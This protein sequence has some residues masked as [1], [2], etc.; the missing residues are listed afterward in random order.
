MPGPAWRWTLNPCLPA[1]ACL[2][3]GGPPLDRLSPDKLSLPA[4]PFNAM[5]NSAKYSKMPPVACHDCPPAVMVAAAGCLGLTMLG[6]TVAFNA[7]ASIGEH[8]GGGKHALW[9]PS[10][11]LPLERLYLSRPVSLPWA[12]TAAGPPP[13]L[14]AVPPRHLQASPPGTSQASWRPY[15]H[16]ALAGIIGLQLSYILPI[17]LRLTVARKWFRKGERGTNLAP[18]IPDGCPA[19]R[20]TWEPPELHALRPI[21]QCTPLSFG[22]LQLSAHTPRIPVT[23]MPAGP[24]HLGPFS[25]VVGWV[26]VVWGCFI[27]VRAPATRKVVN[28]GHLPCPLAC[29]PGLSCQHVPSQATGPLARAWAKQLLVQGLVPPVAQPARQQAS[30]PA[31]CCPRVPVDRVGTAHSLPCD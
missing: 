1:C 6:S 14:G 11:R 27:S 20:R 17:F 16:P 4:Q 18:P 31:H 8:R 22:A 5:T 28:P 3:G 19:T 7:I 9:L 10:Q 24:F 25:I 2:R 21:T 13:V 15:T 12:C 26:A 29:L 30:T 23:L